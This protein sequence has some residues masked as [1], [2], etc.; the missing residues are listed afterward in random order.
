MWKHDDCTSGESSEGKCSLVKK[1]A[2]GE[3]K[4]S[5]VDKGKQAETDELLKSV[6]CESTRKLF[7]GM[8]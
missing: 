6:K 8:L 3:A 7:Q 5:K 2:E 1:K 4:P